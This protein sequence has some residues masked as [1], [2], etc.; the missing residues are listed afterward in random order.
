MLTTT[1]PGPADTEPLLTVD[2]LRTYF[3]VRRGLL[4]RTVG[5]VQAVDGV[6]LRVHEQRPWGWSASLAAASPP[7]G[8]AS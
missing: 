6:S 4:R 3:P 8:A 5:H 2:D 7:W 1:P